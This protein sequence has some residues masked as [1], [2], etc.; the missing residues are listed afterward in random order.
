MKQPVPDTIKGVSVRFFANPEL[1]RGATE[2]EEMCQRTIG[3]LEWLRDK[4]PPIVLMADRQNKDPHCVQ[5]RA[6]GRAVANVDKDAAPIIRGILNTLPSGIVITQITDVDVYKHGF[7]YVKMPVVSRDFVP[8]DIGVDWSQWTIEAPLVLPSEY[9]LREEELNGVIREVLLPDIASSDVGQLN[10]YFAL[11]MGSIRFNHSREVGKDMQEYTGILSA[12]ERQE[13]RQLAKELDHLRTK[14]GT[15]E[16]IRELVDT[17]W[18]PLLGSAV[19]GDNFAL[20]RQRAMCEKCQL[21]GILDYVERLM[22]PMPGELYNDVGDTQKFFSHLYYLAPPKHAL[23][24]VLSLLAI[25]TLICRELG[26]G[27][28]PCFGSRIPEETDVRLMPTTIGR[29]MDFAEHQCREYGESLT[30]QRLVDWL[31]RDCRGTRNAQIEAMLNTHNPAPNVNIGTLVGSAT[32]EVTQE[33]KD[34][35]KLLE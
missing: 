24:G 21:L 14:K 7:F 4:R 23:Q 11:W 16:V 2:T 17:W 28:E 10:E 29:V 18:E 5:M 20:I 12:D 25:R 27:M 15:P 31:E 26:L 13:V 30:M 35:P 34:A 8:E 6:M 19:V 3:V 32:G 22:R 1:G 9:F 33:F